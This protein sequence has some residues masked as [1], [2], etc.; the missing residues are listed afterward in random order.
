[1]N[2]SILNKLNICISPIERRSHQWMRCK[3]QVRMF[4][5][6]TVSEIAHMEITMEGQWGW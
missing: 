3:L 2:K 4:V 5:C 6:R 1:M